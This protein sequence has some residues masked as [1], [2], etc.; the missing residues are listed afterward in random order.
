MQDEFTS[1]GTIY[2][3]FNDPQGMPIQPRGA[4][5]VIG[6]VVLLEEY[7]PGLTDLEEFSHIILIYHFHQSTGHELMVTPFLDQTQHGVFATRAPR[8]PNP[9]GLSIVQLVERQSNELI[10]RGIDVLNET[11]LLDIKP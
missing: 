4:A 3:P 2:S 1:I 7:E 9:I 10:V 5:E 8:R 11:P 6:R